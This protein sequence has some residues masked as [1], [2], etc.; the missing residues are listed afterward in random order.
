MAAEKR[1]PQQNLII[2]MELGKRVRVNDIICHDD[3]VL[4]FHQKTEDKECN[5][6][7]KVIKRYIN[8]TIHHQ[9]TTYENI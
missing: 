1:N 4:F 3:T 5:C 7:L 8:T 9:I 6:D 2:K